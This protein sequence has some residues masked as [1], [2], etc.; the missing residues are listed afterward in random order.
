MVEFKPFSFAKYSSNWL[1]IESYDDEIFFDSNNNILRKP[2][3]DYMSVFQVED[4]YFMC[5]YVI[6]DDFTYYKCDTLDG[7]L[8]LLEEKGI[9]L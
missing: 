7:L 2:P 9:I 6:G 1:K 3:T 8:Q 5:V 4:D